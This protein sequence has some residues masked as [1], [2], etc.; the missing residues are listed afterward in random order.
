MLRCPTSE[1]PICPAGRPTS[2]PDVRSSACGQ[3][4][5]NRSNTGVFARRIALSA[6][7]SRQPKPSSTTS[8]TGRFFCISF[9]ASRCVAAFFAHDL[10]RPAYARRSINPYDATAQGLRAGGKPLHIPDRGRGHAF[11][12][13]ALPEQPEP[14][15]PERTDDDAPPGEQREAVARHVVEE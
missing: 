1:L 9:P 3:L 10:V 15:Q 14:D 4:A 13:H 8:I 5:H 11:R 12:D 7:S 2:A 6:V